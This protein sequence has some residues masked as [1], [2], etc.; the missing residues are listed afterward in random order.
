MA[1]APEP[2]YYDIL[3]VAPTA[4]AAEIRSAF[5][6]QARRYHPDV[7]KEPGAARR[8]QLAH[9][10]HDILG[11]PAKRRAYDE[12]RARPSPRP[13]RTAPSAAPPGRTSGAG[14][15]RAAGPPPSSAPGATTNDFFSDV[16]DILSSLGGTTAGRA[17]GRPHMARDIAATVTIDLEDAA[18][19]VKRRVTVERDEPCALCHGSGVHGG[20]GLAPCEACHGTGFATPGPGGKP[21]PCARC[22]G[23]GETFSSTC[24]GCAGTGRVRAPHTLE[25]TIPAG[26]DDGQR[27]RLAGQGQRGA[28][29]SAP[30]DLYLT[31]RVRPHRTFTRQGDDVHSRFRLTPAQARD[32]ARADIQTLYGHVA[33]TIPPGT[34]DGTTFRLRGQGFPRHGGG[35]GDHFAQAQVS[36]AHAVPAD[37]ARTALRAWTQQA[38]RRLGPLK[39]TLAKRIRPL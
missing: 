22:D 2:D 14:A 23:V 24:A 1:A 26:I 27:I 31:V 36:A 29:G 38:R 18:R 33:L 20:P 35:K 30:G 25:V 8:F 32:G 5:R 16:D 15:R 37:R 39:R 6:A 9:D 34:V 17:Q 21:R 3:G 7:N 11:D 19:G 13:S 4:G 10:A 28:P 12:R